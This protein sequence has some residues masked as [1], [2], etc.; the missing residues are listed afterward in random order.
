MKGTLRI[1][2]IIFLF[3]L[4]LSATAQEGWAQMWADLVLYNG[5]ILTA[6]H[7]DPDRFTIAEAVAVFGDRIVG[8]GSSQAML[9]I[10]GP[11]TRRIDLGGRTMIPGRIDTHVHI[12]NGAA[13]RYLYAGEGQRNNL[14]MTHGVMWT[15]KED[16]LAQ[17]R[18]ITMGKEPGEWVVIQPTFTKES[19]LPNV[20]GSFVPPFLKSVRRE[21]LD[22]VTPPG[23]PI[24]IATY[25]YDDSLVNTAALEILL[26]NV[27]DVRGVDRDASGKP[28]GALMGV[29][30]RT[31][32]LS[33][34]PD[35]DRAKMLEAF[36]K[37]GEHITAQGITTVHTRMEPIPLR[38]YQ[39]LDQRGEMNVRIAY[40]SEILVDHPN[41]EMMIRRYDTPPGAG[42]PMLWNTGFSLLNL[43]LVVSAASACMSKAY[44]RESIHFPVW[45]FQ[46][47]GPYGN[48]MM[49]SENHTLREALEAIAKNGGRMTG[50]HVS[51]DGALD[52]VLDVLEPLAEKYNLK[53]MRF[54]V[55]HCSAVRQDQIERSKKLDLAFSCRHPRGLDGGGKMDATEIIWPESGGEM[56]TPFRSL[57]DAGLRPSISEYSVESVPFLGIS[58]AIL[59]DFDDGRILG[60]RQR[61]NRKEALY[62]F[63]RWAADYMWK[64]EELGSIEVG[65]YADFTVLDRDYLTIPDEEIRKIRI[66][67][68]ILGGKIVYTEPEYATASGL[69]QVG[70]RGTLRQPSNRPYGMSP[71][72]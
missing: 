50:T 32:A 20:T 1:P 35:D 61:V 43:D 16:A 12:M 64:P 3:F 26:K 63:T 70:F 65:K 19:D 29:A 27:P 57:I 28:T 24:M 53:E 60:P 69:P 4:A 58:Y 37:Y 40:A 2:T 38:G 8:V 25:A 68:T 17:I 44:P 72:D 30:T 34:W 9:E 71:M 49:R 5:K 22:R 55:D 54:A 11:Q 42:S 10:A 66:L 41:P 14:G 51:G 46:F 6:D 31:I 62:L 47:W 67:L 56:V 18:T 59:R 48:C 45:R 52:D 36:R 33:F 23:V 15:N 7:P 39:D 21:E 13:G